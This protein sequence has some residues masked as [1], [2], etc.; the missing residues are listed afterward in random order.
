MLILEI[1]S[2][3]SK[4]L[5]FFTTF[6]LFIKGIREKKFNPPLVNFWYLSILSIIDS[7][8]YIIFILFL[9]GITVYNEI[10]RWWQ[11]FYILI[12]FYIISSFLIS[13]NNLK[14]SKNIKLIIISLSL[15]IFSFSIIK[16]LDFKEKY[17]TLISIIELVFINI[18]SIRYLLLHTSELQDSKSKSLSTLV[19]GIFLFINISSPYFIIFQ[20]I[21]KTQ[22]SILSS[23]SFINDIAYTVLFISII[24]SIKWQEK[25]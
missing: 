14:N 24:K 17:Y 15:I 7:S 25:N 19:K 21:A 1:L 8:I 3:I 10:S 9:N 2:S 12:E 6:Y 18:F 11:L 22:S 20:L 5:M 13:L 23:L 16:N 4:I